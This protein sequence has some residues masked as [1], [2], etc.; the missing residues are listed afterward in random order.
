MDNIVM[1]NY[2]LDLKSNVEVFVHGTLESTFS[3][4][5][6]LLKDCLDK[7]IECQRK[8]YVLMTKQN[9]YNVEEI[10]S[11]VIKKCLKN[12]NFKKKV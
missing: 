6:E 12:N 11:D 1:E 10:K 7:T 3:D 5:Q 4:N 2:L 8:T 9:M